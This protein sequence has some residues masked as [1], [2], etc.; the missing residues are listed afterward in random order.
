MRLTISVLAALLEKS[1][2][3]LLPLS[4][5]LSALP[6]TSIPSVIRLNSLW[7]AAMSPWESRLKIVMS[8]VL[9]NIFFDHYTYIVLVQEQ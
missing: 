5:S 4:H 2:K 1:D 8:W 6:S 7:T 3:R 9:R